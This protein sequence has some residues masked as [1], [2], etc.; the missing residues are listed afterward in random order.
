MQKILVSLVVALL[1]CGTASA[2]DKTDVMAVVHKW[3]ETFNG[4]D[5]KIMASMCAD[6][7][8]VLDDFAPHVWQGSSACAS[9]NKDYDAFSKSSAISEPKVVIGKAKHLD[10]DASYAYLV[11]PTTYTYNK[12]GKSVT[13]AGMVTMTLHKSAS[14]WKI[15]GWAWA[16]L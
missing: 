3:V 14:G 2:S 13:E 15:S 5:T 9:W 7:A 8:I 4:G 16:D 11:A 6:D 1:A 12:D 10:I